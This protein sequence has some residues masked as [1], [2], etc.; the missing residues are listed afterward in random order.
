MP[1]RTGSEWLLIVPWGLRRLLN[2]IKERYNN[3]IIYITENGVSDRTN[4][5]ED[6]QR[7]NFLR[8]YINEALKGDKITPLFSNF[9]HE[10]LVCL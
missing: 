3:P 2:F 1:I 9:A 8:R 4:T 6:D 5:K 7:C 10:K